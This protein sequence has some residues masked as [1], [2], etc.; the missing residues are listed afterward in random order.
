MTFRDALCLFVVLGLV[1]SIALLRQRPSPGWVVLLSLSLAGTLLVFSI[2]LQ[3]RTA[4]G[5]S[6]LANGAAVLLAV[7]LWLEYVLAPLEAPL[8]WILSLAL[9]W[10]VAPLGAFALTASAEL[11][12]RS[13]H[14]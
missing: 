14:R 7:T 9:A 3:P 6:M 2:R 12:W 8:R 4:R 13:L 11:L 1:F 10:M 5:R